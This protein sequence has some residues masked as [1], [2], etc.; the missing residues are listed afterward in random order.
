M[1]DL[2]DFNALVLDEL[3]RAVLS[4]NVAEIMAPVVGMIAGGTNECPSGTNSGCENSYCEYSHNT[5]TC[6]NGQNCQQ[7]INDHIC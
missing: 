4:E 1:T 7:T 2:I 3:G 6:S 5:W